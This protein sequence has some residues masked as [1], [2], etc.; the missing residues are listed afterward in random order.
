ML[1]LTAEHIEVIRNPTK[2]NYLRQETKG[3]LTERAAAFAQAYKDEKYRVAA[4]IKDQADAVYLFA[5]RAG[6][7]TESDEAWYYGNDPLFHPGYEAKC[8]KMCDYDQVQEEVMR[9]FNNLMRYTKQEMRLRLGDRT[10]SDAIEI[11]DNTAEKIRKA[12][13]V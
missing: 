13:A 11:L 6:I 10:A 12:A 8:R 3:Y 2:D 5:R 9:R 4:Y 7:L 1:E